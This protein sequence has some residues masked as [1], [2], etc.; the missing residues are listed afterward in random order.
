MF[1]QIRGIAIMMN[2]LM[3]YCRTQI[4]KVLW[5]HDTRYSSM[6]AMY[7]QNDIHKYILRKNSR[8]PVN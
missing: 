4:L 2:M 6:S 7:T 8:L 3:I 5:R 1:V